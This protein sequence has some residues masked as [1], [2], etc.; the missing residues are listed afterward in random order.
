MEHYRRLQIAERSRGV[1][2]HHGAERASE[3]RHLP[4]ITPR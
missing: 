4:Q 3:V 1:T 2:V